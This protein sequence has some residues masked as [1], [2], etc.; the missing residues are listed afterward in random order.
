[1]TLLADSI[2]ITDLMSPVWGI[3][4]NFVD[5][6]DKILII[7]VIGLV[8]VFYKKFLNA[9]AGFITGGVGKT[10]KKE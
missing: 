8:I 5:N 10:A 9:I 4:G 7:I 2:N 6:L 1:M 3:V